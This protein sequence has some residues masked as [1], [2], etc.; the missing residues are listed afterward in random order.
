MKQL[1]SEI[2]SSARYFALHDG[3]M[4]ACGNDEKFF[5]ESASDVCYIACKG[6]WSQT[7]GGDT[8]YEVYVKLK[9]YTSSDQG[10]TKSICLTSDD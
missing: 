9:R 4:C 8:A 2:C 6:N 1:C 5:V 3:N 10:Q 7:C